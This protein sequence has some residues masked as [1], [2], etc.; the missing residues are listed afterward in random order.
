MI[1]CTSCNCVEVGQVPPPPGITVGFLGFLNVG[2]ELYE[3]VGPGGGVDLVPILTV[4]FPRQVLQEAVGR[5]LAELPLCQGQEARL[6]LDDVA[7]K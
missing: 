2:V 4:E 3:A 7:G 6:L 1:L 5:L